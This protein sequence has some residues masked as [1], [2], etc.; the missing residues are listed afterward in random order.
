MDL[1]LIYNMLHKAV[2]YHHFMILNQLIIENSEINDLT[3]SRK[4]DRM[5]TNKNVLAVKNKLVHF[6]N[7]ATK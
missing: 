3:N 6:I 1:G 7:K 2:N 5:S 4:K